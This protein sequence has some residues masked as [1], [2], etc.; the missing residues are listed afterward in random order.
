MRGSSPLARGTRF[1]VIQHHLTPRFIPAGAGNTSPRGMPGERRAVHPRWR[2]EHRFCSSGRGWVCGS[3]PLARGTRFQVFQLGSVWRFIPA[4]AGNTA[5]RCRSPGSW[6]VHPRW[7]GEHQTTLNGKTPFTGSSPLARGTPVCQRADRF[8]IAVH[9]RWRG[10]HKPPEVYVHACN[11][12]SPLARGT[13]YLKHPEFLRQ[14]FIPAGAGNTRGAGD[15]LLRQPVHPRWRGEHARWRKRGA[16]EG[17]SSPLARG[18][19]DQAGRRVRVS[20][21][22]PAGAGNTTA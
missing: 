11:G 13:P 20:R 6:A 5:P 8:P 18:T 17:G 19:L 10:E 2:G 22:I 3:S 1:S 15:R 12:S 21:F 4:G 9:P 7:R 16:G 14:R